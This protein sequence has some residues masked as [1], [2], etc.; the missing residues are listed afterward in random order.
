MAQE[1]KFSHLNIFLVYI[2]HLSVGALRKK[3]LELY[4]FMRVFFFV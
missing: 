4:H 1:S 2:E 3:N